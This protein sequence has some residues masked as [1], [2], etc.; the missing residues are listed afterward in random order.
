M[1][2]QVSYTQLHAIR[3]GTVRRVLHRG[4]G[5]GSPVV[6]VGDLLQEVV[7]LSEGESV[8][9]SLQRSDAWSPVLT[10]YKR[11][12]MRHSYLSCWF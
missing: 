4:A 5:S 11:K 10:Y 3:E 1:T 7:H 9:Q 2:G 8:V 12:M 6:V